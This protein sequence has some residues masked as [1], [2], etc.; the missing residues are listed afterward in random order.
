M[1]A[2]FELDTSL[3]QQK[4]GKV[5]ALFPGVHYASI[6]YHGLY[7]VTLCYDVSYSMFPQTLPIHCVQ[8]H[9][10]SKM[11]TRYVRPHTK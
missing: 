1:H 6:D 8:P 9:R 3:G 4:D 7:D 5:C 11:F 2:H 10:L